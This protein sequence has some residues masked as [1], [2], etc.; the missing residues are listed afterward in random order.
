MVFS[1]TFVMQL[2]IQ[3]NL[4]SVTVAVMEP[5]FC[6]SSTPVRGKECLWVWLMGAC[7]PISCPDSWT[8]GRPDT[9]AVFCVSPLHF[10]LTKKLHTTFPGTQRGR[11]RSGRERFPSEALFVMMTKP[12]RHFR[13]Q[14]SDTWPPALINSSWL[15]TRDPSCSVNWRLCALCSQCTLSPLGWQSGWPQLTGW[16]WTASSHTAPA[17]IWKLIFIREKEA[18]TVHYCDQG[19]DFPWNNCM[20]LDYWKSVCVIHLDN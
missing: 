6:L 19:A 18:S 12:V 20:P 8:T 1:S 15:L 4:C 3:A 10:H 13:C 5:R 11:Q 17:V 2:T 7:W 16:C 14:L 9:Q